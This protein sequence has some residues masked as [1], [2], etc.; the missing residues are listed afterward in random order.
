MKLTK[1]GLRADEEQESTREDR[2]QDP[3]SF[4]EGSEGIQTGLWRLLVRSDRI[5]CLADTY[6]ILHLLF[7]QD[8]TAEMRNNI[9]TLNAH[10]GIYECK[11]VKFLIT[12]GKI[13]R[14]IESRHY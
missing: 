9:Q 7:T 4:I 13:F 6:I 1:P 5:P 11:D 12:L 14:F 8:Q 3:G 10:G 2:N